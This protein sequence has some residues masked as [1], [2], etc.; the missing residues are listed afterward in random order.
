VKNIYIDVE[1][2]GLNPSTC[3]IWQLSGIIEIDG[4][5]REIFNL[6][7]RPDPDQTINIAAMD[8]TKYT[9]EKLIK[10]TLSQ[11]DLYLRFLYILDNYINKFDKND[12]FNFIGYNSHSFD[13]N[14]IRALFTRN[15]NNF[16][17][18]YFYYPSID[19]MILAA[20]AAIGQRDK[21][22]D[23]KLTTVAESLGLTVDIAKAH[24]ALYDVELTRDIY[25]LIVKE[26][27]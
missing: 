23:F 17:G 3:A 18:S 12:K 2:T 8:A 1:T 22:S 6:F 27:K 15:N 16:Y 5:E 10:H 20:F 24:N 19:V 21:L 11:A 4:I 26:F 14:F 13:S 7:A 9:L 25:K